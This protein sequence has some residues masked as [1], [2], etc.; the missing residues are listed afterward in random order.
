MI[1]SSSRLRVDLILS[2]E[3]R[4][5]VDSPVVTLEANEKFGS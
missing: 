1:V 3:S 4:D 2:R 5:S